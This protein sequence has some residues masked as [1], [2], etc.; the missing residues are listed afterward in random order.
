MVPLGGRD[1]DLKCKIYRYGH[2]YS[3]YCIIR[4]WPPVSKVM[5][6][7]RING[8]LIRRRQADSPGAVG[9]AR[10]ELLPLPLAS[11]LAH[12]IAQLSPSAAA[13]QPRAVRHETHA[14]LDCDNAD[15]AAVLS[16]CALE[17][18]I[19]SAAEHCPAPARGAPAQAQ[20]ER[21]PC[22]AGIEEAAVSNYM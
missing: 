2:S 11:P 1:K 7:I 6:S 9:D 16:P 14:G 13:E 18:A 15:S 19:T 4:R 10:P 5:Q 8:K 3:Q 17:S 20:A 12:A 22:A 21:Y